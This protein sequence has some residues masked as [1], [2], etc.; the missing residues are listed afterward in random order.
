[1]EFTKIDDN[2]IEVIK[3]FP[4]PTSETRKYEKKFLEVQ[5]TAIQN[6][7]DRDNEAREKE[8]AEVRELLECFK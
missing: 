5:L 7:Q 1:M 2:T 6:Q 8:K 3:E 4:K